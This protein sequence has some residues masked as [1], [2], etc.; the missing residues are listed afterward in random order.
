M[1]EAIADVDVVILMTRWAEF[2]AL[3]DMLNSLSKPPLLIDGR[4]MLSKKAVPRY[5]GIGL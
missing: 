4:R 5:E 3:P 2:K 1:A